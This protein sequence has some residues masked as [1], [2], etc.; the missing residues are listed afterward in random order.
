MALMRFVSSVAIPF[1]KEARKRRTIDEIPRKITNNFFVFVRVVWWL[2]CSIKP[3]S[4]LGRRLKGFPI[5]SLP[6]LI[7]QES[8]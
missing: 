8:L 3:N 7:L 6:A 5:D 4:Q 2:V 1:R